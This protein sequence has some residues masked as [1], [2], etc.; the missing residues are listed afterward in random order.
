MAT[1]LEVS[2]DTP[3]TEGYIIY[4]WWNKTKLEWK[5]SMYKTE[6]LSVAKGSLSIK[7]KT[8]DLVL[9]KLWELKY[10]EDWTYTLY[11]SDLWVKTNSWINIEMRYAKV[12]S[13]WS[14]VFSLSQNEVASTIYVVSWVV[15]VQNLAWKEAFLQKGDKLVI[16]R[17]NTNDDKSDLSLSK[18]QIDD[19]IK[20]DDWFVKNNWNYYLSLSWTNISSSWSLSYSWSTLSWYVLWNDISGS[21][22]LSFN[23]IFDEQEVNTNSL[24]IEWTI[25]SDM[26]YRIEINGKNV[27]L[28]NNSKTFSLR[29][30]KLESKTNDLVYKIYDEWNKLITKWVITIYY[31]GWNSSNNQSLAKVENYPILSSPLYQILSPKQNPYTT[32]DDIVRIEWTVPSWI[33]EKIVVNDF[34]LRKFPKYWSYWSYFANSQFWNL[35]DWVNIYK[36]QYFG[37]WG[38]IL[39][40]NNFTIIKEPKKLETQ[41]WTLENTFSENTSSWISQEISTWVTQ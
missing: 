35:K 19:Y 23:N 27:E 39:Y 10:N 37:A 13:D 18:E 32:S 26:V 9:N 15:K 38:K 3:D 34:E 7:S 40:E 41:T 33:V 25:L 16:M 4:T 30:L 24:D 20:T 14:S 31:S 8:A 12:S 2:L 22:Y 29:W 11:S 17:N 5:I 28:N 6:K 21:S 36:I 1:P